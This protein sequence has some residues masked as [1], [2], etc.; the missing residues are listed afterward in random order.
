M[1]HTPN[2]FVGQSGVSHLTPLDVNQLNTFLAKA[3]G[4][5]P[6]TKAEKIATATAFEPVIV[7]AM[8]ERLSVARASGRAAYMNGRNMTSNPYCS[9]DRPLEWEAWS[10]GFEQSRAGLETDA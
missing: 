2:S 1:S 10:E 4:A 5:R 8:T 3:R 7:D 6:L 9:D